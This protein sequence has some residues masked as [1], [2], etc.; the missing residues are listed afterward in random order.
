[1]R[2]RLLRG[3]PPAL[4]AGPDHEGVH[5][6]LHPLGADRHLSF[7]QKSPLFA[8]KLLLA[9]CRNCVSHRSYIRANFR[10]C[11]GGSC[12]LH[13]CDGRRGGRLSISLFFV[14]RPRPCFRFSLYVCLSL[15]PSHTMNSAHPTEKLFPN[16]IKV[17]SRSFRLIFLV[18]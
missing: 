7:F 14:A 13:V 6:A 1:M 17:I 18:R 11:T 5:G 8:R 12:L 9:D 15:P 16:W 4:D 10:R 2:P 3:D